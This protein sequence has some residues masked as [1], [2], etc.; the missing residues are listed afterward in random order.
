MKKGLIVCLIL[1]VGGIF[2]A[3]SAKD[4]NPPTI[5]T[6]RMDKEGFTPTDITI[7]KGDV[8]EFINA[9]SLDCPE[10]DARCSFWPASNLHP[11]HDEYPEFDPLKPLAPGE[12]WSFKFNKVGKWDFHDHLKSRLRGTVTV[13]E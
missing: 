3:I 12:S 11:T 4:S 7:N 10:S 5:V 8:V 1:I 13:I 9:M 6:I 2:F